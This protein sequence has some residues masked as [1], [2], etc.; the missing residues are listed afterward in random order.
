LYTDQTILE[1]GF[2]R[3]A[4]IEMALERI[5][6]GKG[7]IYGTEISEYMK[8]IAFYEINNTRR[9]SI[10]HVIHKNKLLHP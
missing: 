5:A 6:G 9:V 4:G 3:G 2:G 10:M 7:H 8:D 1:I